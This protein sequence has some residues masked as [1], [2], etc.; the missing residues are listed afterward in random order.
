MISSSTSSTQF[1]S[2]SG[3]KKD[4]AYSRSSDVV[5][6]LASLR[7]THQ[8]RQ[9]GISI[10][11]DYIESKRK[12]G[13]SDNEIRRKMV[14]MQNMIS[15]DLEDIF[16]KAMS[17]TELSRKAIRSSPSAPIEFSRRARQSLANLSINSLTSIATLNT[18]PQD[19]AVPVSPAPPVPFSQEK[20]QSALV[21]DKSIQNLRITTLINEPWPE[22]TSPAFEFS[23]SPES[24]SSNT[25][26]SEVFSS[27][28]P[29]CDP[30]ESISSSKLTIPSSK[31]LLSPLSFSNS[32]VENDK[33]SSSLRRVPTLLSPLAIGGWG[34]QWEKPL[35]E[36]KLL[37][38]TQVSTPVSA[39]SQISFDVITSFPHPPSHIPHTGDLPGISGGNDY[40]DDNTQISASS[41]EVKVI[42][43]K[44]NKSEVNE[45]WFSISEDL[46]SGLP[47]ARLQSSSWTMD[48]YIND[49]SEINKD[50]EEDWKWNWNNLLRAQIGLDEF[51]DDEDDRT[52]MA[53]KA[54]N[55][56]SVDF[57]D[58]GNEIDIPTNYKHPFTLN[59]PSEAALIRDTYLRMVQTH[60]IAQ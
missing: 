55:R 3:V 27:P 58:Y 10:L 60:K 31:S 16:L 38:P 12:R 5:N 57:S 17:K 30:Q 15:A 45:S 28:S 39:F 20:S 19:Q 42:E 4:L 34:R 54:A 26:V 35:L 36:D 29:L 33:R 52:V 43:Q 11:C 32:F 41:I 24:A 1:P 22:T 14:M 2:T 49:A 6:F 21:S 48:D 13:K 7:N 44:Q 56:W 37:T 9:R 25:E 18:S 47:S 23:L 59:A 8:G 40:H 50:D 51:E 46:S 53:D